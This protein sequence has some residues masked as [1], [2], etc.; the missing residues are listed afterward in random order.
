MW[1]NGKNSGVE[2][3]RLDRIGPEILDRKEGA[4][5]SEPQFGCMTKCILI[6]TLFIEICPADK[7]WT[8]LWAAIQGARSQRD[9]QYHVDS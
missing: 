1:R 9:S 2:Q 3:E 5:A 6:R 4:D 7:H 8:W